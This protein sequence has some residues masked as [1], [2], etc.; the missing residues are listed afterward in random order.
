MRRHGIKCGYAE[1]GVLGEGAAS[2]SPPAR[3]SV[4]SL[5][6]VRGRAPE[7]FEFGAFGDLKIASEQCKMMVEVESIVVISSRVNDWRRHP[8]DR[9]VPKYEVGGLGRQSVVK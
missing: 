6:G 7:N 5:S 9:G 3:G 8:Y 1:C 2:S 4:S